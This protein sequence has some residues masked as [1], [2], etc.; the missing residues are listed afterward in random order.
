MAKGT[1]RVNYCNCFMQKGTQ[2]NQTCSEGYTFLFLY[3]T[4][5]FLCIWG[6][7][8]RLDYVSILVLSPVGIVE[9]TDCPPQRTTTHIRDVRSRTFRI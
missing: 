1:T 6:V 8:T 5:V 7:I 3:V 9:K 4:G 2:P